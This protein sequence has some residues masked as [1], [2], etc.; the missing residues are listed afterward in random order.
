MAKTPYT[1]AAMKAAARPRPT[2]LDQWNSQLKKLPAGFPGEDQPLT[3]AQARLGA[4]TTGGVA[5]QDKNNNNEW[6]F[7]PKWAKG[8]K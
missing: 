4:K 8:K 5:T 3:K 1:D 6:V 7:G 2:R